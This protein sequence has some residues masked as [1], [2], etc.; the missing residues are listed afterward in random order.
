MDT[1]IAEWLQ[2]ADA[3]E[4]LA[5][6]SDHRG[7]S[8]RMHV[9]D[10]R[11]KKKGQN[12]CRRGWVPNDNGEGEPV[13]YHDALSAGLQKLPSPDAIAITSVVVE[14]ATA[15]AQ[16]P[17]RPRSGAE[18]L[19]HIRGLIDARRESNNTEERTDISNRLQ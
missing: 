4:Y 3:D 15:H 12:M 7:V 9:K 6:R 8:A 10:T 1:S 16:K 11:R 18:G 13:G 5:D 2:D 14:A 17:A 19:E